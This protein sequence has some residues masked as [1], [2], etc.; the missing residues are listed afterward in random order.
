MKKNNLRNV[1]PEFYRLHREFNSGAKELSGIAWNRSYLVHDT[2]YAMTVR[3]DGKNR[4]ERC[5]TSSDIVETGHL[6]SRVSNSNDCSVSWSYPVSSGEYCDV[7]F[8][9]PLLAIRRLPITL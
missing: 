3:M 4:A 9:K 6:Y 2:L 1:N 5:V 7:S 8:N